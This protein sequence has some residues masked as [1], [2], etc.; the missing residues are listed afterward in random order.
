MKFSAAVSL[1]LALAVSARPMRRQD[2]TAQNV[3]EAT[4]LKYVVP[5]GRENPVSSAYL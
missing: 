2:F 1:A 3:K 4:D 5:H